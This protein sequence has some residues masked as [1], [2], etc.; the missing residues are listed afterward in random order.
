MQL[1]AISP[2]PSS[3]PYFGFSHLHQKMASG[4]KMY[5]NKNTLICLPVAK[6]GQGEIEYIF[7]G[8]DL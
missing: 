3:Y 8:K 7:M 1:F 4:N 5:W 2:F 6:I